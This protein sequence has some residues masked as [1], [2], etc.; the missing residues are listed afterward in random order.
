MKIRQT[1][2]EDLEL[3]L[4][5]GHLDFGFSD[6][7]SQ[8]KD[9]FSHRLLTSPIRFYVA[10]Q[11]AQHSLKEIVQK[12]PL[13]LCQSEAST[14]AFLQK[15]LLD[16]GIS[17]ISL[18]KADYPGILL[19]MCRS[20]LGVGAFCEGTEGGFSAGQLHS[21]QESKNTPKIQTETYLLWAANGESTTAV[22]Q[23]KRLMIH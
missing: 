21:L 12:I 8:R 4:V 19:D 10:E 1:S 13:L 3:L 15:A 7:A 11:W 23:A 17:P 9:V 18:V 20:G 2:L 16:V 5:K 6:Q 14:D 22:L